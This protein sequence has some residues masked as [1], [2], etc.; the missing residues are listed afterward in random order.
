VQCSVG[1][2]VWCAR[3]QQCLL[4]FVFWNIIEIYNNLYNMIFNDNDTNIYKFITQQKLG[5]I[6]N[7]SLS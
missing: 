1:V 2:L 5:K 4:Y 3:Q 6:L 7:Q